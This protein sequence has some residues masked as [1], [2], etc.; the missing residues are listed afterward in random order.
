MRTFVVFQALSCAVLTAKSL[1]ILPQLSSPIP[2]KVS[3]LLSYLLRPSCL[4]LSALLSSNPLFPWL[5]RSWA[6]LA[7]SVICSPIGPAMILGTTSK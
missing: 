1:F 7:D 5:S 6:I 3:K 2:S 4:L